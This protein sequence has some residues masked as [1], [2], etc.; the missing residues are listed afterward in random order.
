MGD[1]CSLKSKEDLTQR[2]SKS[3]F[4]TNFPDQFSARDLWNVCNAY[5]KMVD[6]YILLKKSKAGKKFAFVSFL[7]VDNLDRLVDNLYT[8]W[9]GRLRLHANPI[10]YQKET[11]AS[12]FKSIKVN[13]DF[14]KNSFVVV[15]D[16]WLYWSFMDVFH[17]LLRLGWTDGAWCGVIFSNKGFEHINITY[18]E[19][20]WVRID[21]NSLSSKEKISKHV[22][23]A[24]WFNELLPASNSYVS[25]E[26]IVWISVEGLPIKTWTRNTFA[27]IV[28]PW[29]KLS[30]VEA[31]DDSLFP[32]KKLCMIT[33][34]NVIIN[35][36]IKVIVKG[37]VYWIRVR[38]LDVWTP[39]FNNDLNDNSLAEGDF[40]DG[41]VEHISDTKGS[42]GELVKEAEIDHVSEFSFMNNKE[43]ESKEKVVS[44]RDDPIFPP[45]F[46]P[47]VIEETVMDNNDG[48][49]TRPNVNL[50]GSN[51][52]T[53]SARS[54]S[55]HV[56][57]L[58]PGGSILEVM[59]NL[60]EVGQTMGYN[61]DRC[62]QTIEAIIGSQGEFQVFR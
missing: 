62:M 1:Y 38:E 19:G 11:R 22:G 10:R 3:V 7:K 59:E 9:I 43:D 47:D 58:K 4:V 32:F 13:E 54:G 23:V 49:T 55:N 20:F 27:K 8:I 53:S 17:V 44:K 2:I 18:L 60:V 37:R 12:S 30:E 45:G 29:G 24:S 16:K 61:M 52:G 6:V 5:G 36:K 28:T 39:E 14:A 46:T 31:E 42:E 34:P 25:D 57:K 51:E 50:H 40:E 33:R 21:S 35:D 48:S 56:S 41:V 15:F 26:R